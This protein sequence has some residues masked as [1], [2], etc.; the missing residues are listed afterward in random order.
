MHLHLQMMVLLQ[1]CFGCRQG[2][3]AWGGGAK[4]VAV[5]FATS[6]PHRDYDYNLDSGGG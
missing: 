2:F 6:L 5:P 3:G 1:L 4:R